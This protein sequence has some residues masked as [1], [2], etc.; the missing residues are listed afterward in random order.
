MLNFSEKVCMQDKRGRSGKIYSGDKDSQ[1]KKRERET[2]AQ[3]DKRKKSAVRLDGAWQGVTTLGS[4]RG[5][6]KIREGNTV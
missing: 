2:F 5:E 6:T 4:G 1:C 3:N